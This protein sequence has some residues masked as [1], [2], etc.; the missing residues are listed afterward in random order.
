MID[1]HYTTEE[2]GVRLELK[3]DMTEVGTFHRMVTVLYALDWNIVSGEVRTSE[4]D[5]KTFADNTLFLSDEDGKK[6]TKVIE[7]GILMDTVFSAK[8][9]LEEILHEYTIPKVDPKK[10]FGKD[11]ELIFFDEPKVGMTCFHIEAYSAKGLLYHV[12]KALADEKISIV[13]G[14]IET[15]ERTGKAKDTFYLLDSQ[16]RMFASDSVTERIR[17]RIWNT[18]REYVKRQT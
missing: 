10:F 2:N 18:S 8:A 17:Q 5:G 4:K 3:T 15:D 13:S 7:I 9:S 14:L 12:T 16:N 1:F 6:K 11:F